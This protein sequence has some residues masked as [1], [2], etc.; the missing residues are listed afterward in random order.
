MWAVKFFNQELVIITQR[1]QNKMNQQ[2]YLHTYIQRNSS[3]KTRNLETHKKDKTERSKE[4]SPGIERNNLHIN[5]SVCFTFG[6]TKLQ[7]NGK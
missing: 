4:T 1:K 5:F 3:I 6:T 7:V 2:N